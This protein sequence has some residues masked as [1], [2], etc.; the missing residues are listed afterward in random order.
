MWSRK[1]MSRSV[2]KRSCVLLTGD[3]RI[4]EDNAYK[5]EIEVFSDFCCCSA[6]QPIMI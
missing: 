4:P 2:I 5:T 3:K 1:F 6:R